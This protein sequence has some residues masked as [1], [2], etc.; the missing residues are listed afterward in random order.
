MSQ[1]L[2]IQLELVQVPEDPRDH[3]DAAIL[4]PIL[5]TAMFSQLLIGSKTLK[6][7]QQEQ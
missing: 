5:H 4:I 1:E 7:K 6:D 3:V 2:E